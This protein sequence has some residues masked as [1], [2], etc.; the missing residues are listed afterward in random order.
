MHPAGQSPEPRKKVISY[1]VEVGLVSTQA[2]CPMSI[3]SRARIPRNDGSAA[4]TAATASAG[5]SIGGTTWAA[6][7]LVAGGEAVGTVAAGLVVADADGGPPAPG[8]QPAS[9]N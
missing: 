6:G 3:G 2:D 9:D 5:V 1:P 7:G 4:T 8:A